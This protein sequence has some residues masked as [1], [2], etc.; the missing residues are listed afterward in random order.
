MTASGSHSTRGAWIET[1]YIIL[2]QFCYEV[3]LH[4]GCVDRNVTPVGIIP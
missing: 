4:E 3:A 1:Y 2:N